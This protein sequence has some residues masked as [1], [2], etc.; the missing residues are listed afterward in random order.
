MKIELDLSSLRETRWYEYAVRFLFGGVMTVITGLIAK[1]F[2]PVVGGLFLAFP[3]ILPASAT[4][5]E[6]HEKEKKQAAG[7]NGEKRGRQVASVDAAGAA[8]GTLGLFVFALIVRQFIS[9]HNAWVV[10]LIATLVSIS[11]SVLAWLIRKRT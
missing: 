3:A 6:K 11:V 10:L 4:L 1:K 7:L 5:I 8:M 2:G 9:E